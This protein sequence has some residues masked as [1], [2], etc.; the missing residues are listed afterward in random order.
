M[1][2]R[3][4]SQIS[5]PGLQESCLILTRSLYKEFDLICKCFLSITE[6]QTLSS[7]FDFRSLRTILLFFMTENEGRNYI[8]DRITAHFSPSIIS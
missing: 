2:S 5:D 1:D 7:N 6:S 8:P 3:T 4:W